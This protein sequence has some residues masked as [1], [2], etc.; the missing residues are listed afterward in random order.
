MAEPF[1]S[2]RVSSDPR[3][4]AKRLRQ[5]IEQQAPQK[6]FYSDDR[7]RLIYDELEDLPPDIEI[8][9]LGTIYWAQIRERTFKKLEADGLT[10][11]KYFGDIDRINTLLSELQEALNSPVVREKPA[12]GRVIYHEP[13]DVYCR[14]KRPTNDCIAIR[15]MLDTLAKTKE[16][17]TDANASVTPKEH[18]RRFILKAQCNFLTQRLMDEGVNAACAKP[19]DFCAICEPMKADLFALIEPPGKRTLVRP[20]GPGAAPDALLAELVIEIVGKLTDAKWS[21]DDA[22]LLLHRICVYCLDMSE[23]GPASIGALLQRWKR[24]KRL[25][26]QL[27][28]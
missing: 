15:K 10:S 11:D 6:P 24:W 16:A 23:E 28:G 7:K 25:R 26:R 17:L 8:P 27:K 2:K 9:I 14:H 4:R 20:R 13:H 3:Q 1:P 21:P 19:E 22:C 18:E 12:I 5:E